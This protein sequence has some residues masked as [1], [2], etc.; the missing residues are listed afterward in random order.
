MTTDAA[1]RLDR[2]RSL[3]GKA[4]DSEIAA[5]VGVKVE[6]VKAY[7]RA[8]D[9][10]P[11]L[12]AAPGVAARTVAAPPA[13]ARAA[14]AGTNAPPTVVR[15]RSGE[16]GAPAEEVRRQIA[17]AEP[18]PAHPLEAYRDQLGK[19]ADDVIASRAGVRRQVV[20]EFRRAAGIDPYTGHWLRGKRPP[21]GTAVTPAPAAPGAE[22]AVRSSAAARASVAASSTASAQSAAAPRKPRGTRAA[23]VDPAPA[24]AAPLEG[25]AIGVRF[26]LPPSAGDRRRGAGAASVPPGRPATAAAPVAASPVPAPSAPA[27]REVTVEPTFKK[28]KLDA[29]K[30]LIGVE[31]DGV[32]AARANASAGGVKAYRERHGIAAAPRAARVGVPT[33]STAVVQ[34]I[35]VAP[36]EASTPRLAEESAVRTARP[37]KLEA[38]RDIVG[39]LSDTAVAEVA[40]V[41]PSGVRKFRARHG[42]PP[43]VASGHAVATAPAK[44]PDAPRITRATAPPHEVHIAAVEDQGRTVP[45]AV[46]APAPVAVVAE[47]V[48]EAVHPPAVVPSALPASPARFAFRVVAQ[49]GGE[50]R[51]FIVVGEH[52]GEA[53]MTAVR[54]LSERDDGPWTVQIIKAMEEAL[55]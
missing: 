43:G 12:R 5:E 41:T 18:P 51:R 1:A 37:S 14:P 30:H 15:R 21:G 46:P 11:Y 16:D 50:A 48:P 39:V 52:I 23:A 10:K 26:T 44:M 38:H 20:G 6:D 24:G 29:F 45:A 2:Y 49:A 4:P 55:S 28:G 36:P 9:I 25:G 27:F 17:A 8:H 33:A 3:I 35:T 32:V 19:V 22:S 7:R 53:A 40:G 42:I 31:P 47:N 34:A 54:A 13:V